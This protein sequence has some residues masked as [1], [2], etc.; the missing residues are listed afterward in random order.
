MLHP[1]YRPGDV[2]NV[3]LTDL[4]GLPGWNLAATALVLRVQ[5]AE[6]L[7]YVRDLDMT[8][9]HMYL[10]GELSSALAGA[11]IEHPVTSGPAVGRVV[12]G[13][14]RDQVPAAAIDPATALDALAP[15]FA[16]RAS[17]PLDASQLGLLDTAVRAVADR[18]AA[19]A[20]AVQ[21]RDRLVHRYRAGGLAVAQIARPGLSRS[22]VAQI[23]PTRERSNP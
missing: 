5:G 8:A 17:T 10:L 19:L 4:P 15:H 14:R 13:P 2:L 12:L 20:D 16:A 11:V 7:L 1:A 21:Q 18:R 3:D 23:A 22:L 6:L 9:A